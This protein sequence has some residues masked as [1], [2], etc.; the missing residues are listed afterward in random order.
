MVTDPL[1]TPNRR[2][3]KAGDTRHLAILNAD[4]SVFDRKRFSSPIDAGT[5]GDFFFSPIA[6]MWH[7]NLVPGLY[8]GAF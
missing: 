5:P 8:R 2:Q 4:R 3:P 7:F 1:Q 6:A